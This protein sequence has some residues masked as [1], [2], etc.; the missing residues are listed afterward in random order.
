MLPKK[1]SITPRLAELVAMGEERLGSHRLLS[2]EVDE[3][4]MR[5]LTF[6]FSGGVRAPP[7][8]TYPTEPYDSF[9]I[10]EDVHVGKFVLGRNTNLRSISLIGPQG[11]SLISIGQL[12]YNELIVS[13]YMKKNE[14][15]VAVAVET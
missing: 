12:N 5:S 6:V 13:L 9:E 15:I 7:I 11:E 4:R 1:M 8:G 3:L 14:K 10:E 2:I